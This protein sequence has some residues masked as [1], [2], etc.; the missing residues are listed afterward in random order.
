MAEPETELQIEPEN[1][2]APEPMPWLTCRAPSLKSVSFDTTG[3]ESR[4]EPEPGECRVWCS[5]EGDEVDLLFFPLPPDLPG[6]TTMDD[7]RGV[8]VTMLEPCG[9]NVVEFS[10]RKL[11]DC[12]A[13]RVVSKTQQQQ[14]GLIY[15]GALTIPFREF[16]F[17]LT[18]RCEERG[19]T[20]VRAATLFA[21]HFEVEGPPPDMSKPALNEWLARTNWNP[22]DERFDVQFPDHPVSRVRRVLA[23]L[24]SSTKV[25]PEVRQR[26]RF[27][28]PGGS[29]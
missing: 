2:R 23:H 3:Y 11:D 5:P 18:V 4:G 9:G 6:A 10:V 25:A 8:Y 14:A 13:L 27:P 19:T 24:E 17:M 7:L 16:S 26:P 1:E 20:G 15:V 29:A 21:R 28:L 12:P 22:D